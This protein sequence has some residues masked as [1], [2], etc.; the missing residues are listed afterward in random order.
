M[1][2]LSAFRAFGTPRQAPLANLQRR[3]EY[4]KRAYEQA[5]ADLDEARQA[6]GL[7]PLDETEERQPAFL[8]PD[9]AAQFI[10]A[11]RRR[12]GLAPRTLSPEASA[13]RA[14]LII[15]AD[16]KRRNIDQPDFVPA[17]PQTPPPKAT[18]EEIVAAMTKANLG[19]K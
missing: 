4:Q 9:H 1:K 3:A 14:A 18:A 8:S 16:R 5:Q 12:R 19:R 17:P 2:D 7:G 15:A 11:D 6:Q 13:D 10:E